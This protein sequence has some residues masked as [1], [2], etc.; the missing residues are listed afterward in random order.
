MALS[1]N[2][3]L[4]RFESEH[5]Y[6]KFVFKGQ[7]NS[8]QEV[9]KDFLVKKKKLTLPTDR[10]RATKPDKL[11]KIILINMDKGGEEI[12]DKSGNLIEANTKVIVRRLP[13]KELDP[14]ELSYNQ[15]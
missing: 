11:D 9:F 8:Y 3:I 12:V 15:M 5:T 13:M 1:T 7:T 2:S 10:D 4:I 14:I 6:E